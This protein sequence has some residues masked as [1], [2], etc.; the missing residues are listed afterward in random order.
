MI[1]SMY[2]Y[3]IELNKFTFKI[4]SKLHNFELIRSNYHQSLRYLYECNPIREDVEQYKVKID[5]YYY[6]RLLPSYQNKIFNFDC[7]NSNNIIKRILIWNMPDKWND[8]KFG[9]GIK[10]P[11]IASKCPVVNCELTDD[12]STLKSADLVV[13]NLDHTYKSFP[14][15]SNN[16]K[17]RWSFLIKRSP[18]HFRKSLS[19]FNNF[20]NFSASYTFDSFYTSYFYSYSSIYWELNDEFNDNLNVFQQKTGL[21]A[22]YLDKCD[23][24]SKRFEYINL[25]RNSINVSVYGACGNLLCKSLKKS[26]SSSIKDKDCKQK[27]IYKKYKFYLAFEDSICQD[28]VTDTLFDLLS[29]NIVPVVFDFKNTYSKY[30]PKSAYINALDFK[31]PNELS[32]YLSKIGKDPVKYNRYF[33]WKKHIKSMNSHGVFCDICIKLNLEKYFE[34]KNSIVKS[35]DNFWKSDEYCL[36][37]SVISNQTFII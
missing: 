11:F 17:T 34:T 8:F 15:D 31:T 27:H 36:K 29:F 37:P 23:S 24:F 16:K 20:F 25:M 6:P 19:R 13:V 21:V 5:D 12:H 2:Y 22:I 1:I 7:L 32:D 33:K 14:K 26:S 4:P 18:F 3:K 10:A 28:Y 35:L 30:L 9:M